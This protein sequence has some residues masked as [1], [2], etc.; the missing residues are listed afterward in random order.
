MPKG[1]RR[2]RLAG[3]ERELKA[4]DARRHALIAA[5]KAAVEELTFGSAAPMAGLKLQ[6]PHAAGPG[7]AA[8]RPRK[9]SAAVRARL[10]ELARE[11]WAKAK[12]AGKTR[13]G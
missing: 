1:T 3:L 8:P 12:K 9:F 13:L 7:K 5:I 4:L 10:S 11:R 2:G 6:P